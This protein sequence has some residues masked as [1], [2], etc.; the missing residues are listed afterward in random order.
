MQRQIS[1]SFT[2][3]DLAWLRAR[4]RGR[5][6]LKGIGTAEQVRSAR[7]AG[8]D[9]VVVSNHGGRQL[10][11][12]SSTIETLP[13]IAEAARGDM[14]VLI[15]SGIRSGADIAKAI[16]LGAD[17][18]QLGRATLYGLAA[19]GEAG[20]RHALRMLADD[21]DRSM[22]NCGAANLEQLRGRVMRSAS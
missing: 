8:V 15:D 13:A 21:L 19:N 4:W 2:W 22:G 16:A 5:L 10:D 18:V 14:T 12:A 7:S 17:A 1:S 20:A 3:H 11:G 9:G 6:V